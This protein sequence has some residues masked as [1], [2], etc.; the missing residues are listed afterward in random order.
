MYEKKER[1]IEEY[2]SS[3][4]PGFLLVLN[5]VSQRLYG[6]PYSTLLLRSPSAAYKVVRKLYNRQI[7][8]AARLLVAVPLVYA[9]GENIAGDTVSRVLELIKEGNDKEALH[10]VG[11]S[12]QSV[13]AAGDVGFE[14]KMFKEILSCA[15]EIEKLAAEVYVKL[16]EHFEEPI[17]SAFRYISI[18]SSAHAHIYKKIYQLLYGNG[19]SFICSRSSSVLFINRLKEIIKLLSSKQE[20]NKGM[21]VDKLRLLASMENDIDAEYFMALVSPLLS[22]VLQEPHRSIYE[23]LLEAIAR[24]EEDH[25]RIVSNIITVLT[26]D[27]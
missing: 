11:L 24:D 3:R 13:K 6:I 7:D 21:L 27:D 18:E 5:S 19:G 23:P 4:A 25:K 10:I 15:I 16:A 22:R 20:A 8:I 2:F 1:S 9:S 14:K 17:S 26:K 12:P